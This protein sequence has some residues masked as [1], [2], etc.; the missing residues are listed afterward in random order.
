MEKYESK[1]FGFNKV[2]KSYTS[3]SLFTLLF[4][5]VL[6]NFRYIL[7]QILLFSKFI[8]HSYLYIDKFMVANIL[9]CYL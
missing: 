8:L 7:V 9:Y 5:I 4:V 3:T 6:K 1:N 2:I